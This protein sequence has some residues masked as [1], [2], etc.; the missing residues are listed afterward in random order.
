MKDYNETLIREEENT[1]RG[2]SILNSKETLKYL[3]ISI[4]LLS[5]LCANGA[6]PYYN[7]TGVNGGKGSLRFFKVHD[8]NK[9]MTTYP[10]KKL[11]VK[12]LPDSIKTVS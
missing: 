2:K 1:F 4:S 12:D 7:A 10:N 11:S 8:L 9:W 5:K 6:I 3:G